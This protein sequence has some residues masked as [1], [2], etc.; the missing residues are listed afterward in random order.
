M[1]SVFSTD[2]L[3]VFHPRLQRFNKS[4]SMEDWEISRNAVTIG[5]K[6]GSGSF[7]T[8]FRGEWFGRSWGPHSLSHLPLLYLSWVLSTLL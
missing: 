7:G 8:V 5:R 3:H 4:N 1:Y 2:F 6:I